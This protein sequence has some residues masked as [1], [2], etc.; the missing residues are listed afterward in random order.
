MVFDNL[1]WENSDQVIAS[2]GFCRT[3][4]LKGGNPYD[5]FKK[6]IEIATAFR[7][8]R[9]AEGLAMTN[10]FCYLIK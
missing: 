7:W 4:R 3:V 8:E 10:D 1:P 5:W 9:E 6:E 2:A